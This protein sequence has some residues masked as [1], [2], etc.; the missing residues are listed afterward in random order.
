MNKWSRIDEIVQ[1][2]VGLAVMATY[3]VMT[4]NG[5]DIPWHLVA[6][7]TAVLIYYGFKVSKKTAT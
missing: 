6:A 3:L 1:N 7:V 2:V 5:K 4:I